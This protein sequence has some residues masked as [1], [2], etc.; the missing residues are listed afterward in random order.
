M[1]TLIHPQN[2]SHQ[3]G[4]KYLFLGDSLG[5]LMVSLWAQFE[6][7]NRR[8]HSTHPMNLKS[9][10]SLLMHSF[11]FYAIVVGFCLNFY[12]PFQ[13]QLSKKLDPKFKSEVG[14]PSDLAS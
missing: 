7:R 4:H 10:Q 5:A 1:L 13:L 14:I 9:L 11:F 8:A 2:L 6:K 12:S 3:F